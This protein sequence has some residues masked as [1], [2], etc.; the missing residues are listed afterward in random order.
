MIGD[1]RRG[2]LRDRGVASQPCA[3]PLGTVIDLARAARYRGRPSGYSFK[4]AYVTV[5]AA[6][7]RSF[8]WPGCLLVRLID[9]A[10]WSTLFH[11]A[12]ADRTAARS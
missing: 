12:A 1:R 11:A 2:F 8:L 9:A 5:I 10:T 4:S 3:V 7:W 6:M